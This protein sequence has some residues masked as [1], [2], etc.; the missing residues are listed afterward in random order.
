MT[1]NNALSDIGITRFLIRY[2]VC[3]N[4]KGK[5]WVTTKK[6]IIVTLFSTKPYFHTI[7]PR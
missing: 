3:G 4:C 2:F 1:E 6:N 7:L 5:G